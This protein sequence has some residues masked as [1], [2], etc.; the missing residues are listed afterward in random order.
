MSSYSTERRSRVSTRTVR[1][2]IGTD[3]SHGAVVPPLHLSANYVFDA[4]GEC[5][6]YDYT[7]SGNPTRDHLSEAIAAAEGG[8][9]CVVTSSGM[10]AVSLITQLLEPGDLLLAPHDCYG[11][12]HRL[13]TAESRRVGFE[14]LF[15][16]QSTEA[17]FELARE[18]KPRI[19]W[20]ETPSNP[21]LRVTDLTRWVHIARE[22]GAVSVADNTFLSPANQRPLDLG[23]DLVLHSTT[24]FINGHSD[25]VGGAVVAKD[26][27]LG[28]DLAWWAN[29]IGV[30]GSPFD[31]YLTLRGLRTLYARCE[32]HERNA[33]A[34]VGA[35]QAHKAVAKVYH[36]SLPDHPGHEHALR[37]QTGWGSLVSFELH[38]GRESVDDFLAALRHFTLAESLGGVESLV[39]HPATMTHASMDAEAQRIAGI[40]EGL[41][42]LSVGI[43][44]VDDL[45][46]D[47]RHALDRVEEGL[48]V[49]C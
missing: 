18:R 29:C 37:Q 34:V 9:S 36:P 27:P 1:A 23:V 39:T 8:A 15:V 31:A 28:E 24:K 5:G 20:L 7:R 3:Q 4:P 41:L 45:T 46:A 49:P 35:L 19:V 32:V 21:L 44:H 22:I 33:L 6:R 25:V 13:F 10:A 2:A 12:C 40:G 14:V 47:V 38:G 16:D 11:G 17:A 43:E 30:T 42:R 48:C 26:A